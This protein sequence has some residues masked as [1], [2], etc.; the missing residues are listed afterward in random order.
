MDTPKHQICKSCANEFSGVYC[1]QCG[2]KV[3]TPDDRSFQAILSNF[4]VFS[5]LADIKLVKSLWLI[6]SNPGFLSKEYTEGRRVK[7]LRPLQIF[8]IL[9][10]I[11]FL[12]P[13]LQLFNSSFRT[14]MYYLFHSDWVQN[15]VIKRL[16]SDNISLAGFEMLYNDQ[17]TGL[18]KLLVFIFVFVASLP[19][20]VIF[21]KKNRYFADHVT[22][23]VELACFNFFINAIVLS[24]LLWMG[25]SLLNL[26]DTGWGSHLNDTN[27]TIVFVITN[28]YFLFR[29]A[30]TFY[31][32]K[33]KR[34]IV[35]T[36]IGIM[37]LFL[38]LEVYRLI[39]FFVTFWAV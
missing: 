20:S 19:L 24:V 33:G 26:T 27:L 8:F 29:A 4:F 13:V 7:Y 2:E 36:V 15:I 23:S 22:L 12:F 31:G 9:N 14:Q 1:N 25:N 10:L 18:A 32:Q 3:I 16:S 17:T 6:I 21:L 39:L 5:S 28:M 11:Y 37:G 30:R 35:K 38:A 34:L